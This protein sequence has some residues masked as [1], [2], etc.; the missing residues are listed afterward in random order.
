L[1]DEW[2][3]GLPVGA[4]LGYSRS[5]RTP[6]PAR[7]DTGAADPVLLPRFLA[8][9]GIEAAAIRQAAREPG[10]LAGVLQFLMAHEPTLAAFCEA[11]GEEPARIAAALAALPFGDDRFE[12]ST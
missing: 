8:I 9:S 7:L 3:T 4:G 11:S 10:F 5:M 12:R 2:Q 6:S 1:I